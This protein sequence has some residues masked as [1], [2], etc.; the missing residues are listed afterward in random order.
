[1]SVSSVSST[2][3]IAPAPAVSVKA[4]AADGDFKTKGAGHEVKDA[5]G[6]YRPTAASSTA[7]TTLS[8]VTLLV[9]GG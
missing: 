2:S 1:M 9:K 5:D 6:D 3:P 7:A 8:A 4:T